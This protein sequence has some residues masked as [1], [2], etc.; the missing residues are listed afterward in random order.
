LLPH[1]ISRIAPWDVG[2]KRIAPKN[3]GCILLGLY[4]ELAKTCQRFGPR[5]SRLLGKLERSAVS[6]QVV[7]EDDEEVLPKTNTGITILN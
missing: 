5:F 7:S 3:L 1:L 4:P 2:P 6:D